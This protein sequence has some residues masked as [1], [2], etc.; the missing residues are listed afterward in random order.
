M[1]ELPLSLSALRRHCRRVIIL[2]VVLVAAALLFFRGMPRDL[3]A[4]LE[5]AEQFELLS[6]NPDSEVKGDFHG[7]VVLGTT[8]IVDRGT[9]DE[10]ISA[11][12]SGTRWNDGTV[13]ACF[14]PRHGIRATRG[15]VVTD[16]V[17][18][19]KCHRVRVYQPGTEPKH[20]TVSKS[21]EPVFDRVLTTQKVPLAPKDPM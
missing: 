10:L 2:V 18:C 17:I 9:R 3:L 19:F 14:V 11:L 20:F 15:K 16:F 4:A 1:P 8:T 12:Q 7:F 5:T 21:P 6:V 13:Y